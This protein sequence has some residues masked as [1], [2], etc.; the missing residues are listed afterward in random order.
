MHCK[1]GSALTAKKR[2]I[3]PEKSLNKNMN[4]IKP[5]LK[6][7]GLEPLTIRPESNFVTQNVCGGGC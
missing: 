6:L 4:T 1:T 7:A 2:L 3:A 5:Y